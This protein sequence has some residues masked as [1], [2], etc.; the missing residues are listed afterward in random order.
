MNLNDL[1]KLEDA[2]K[3]VEAATVR[4]KQQNEEAKA[5]LLQRAA[6]EFRDYFSEAGF[7]VQPTQQGIIATI[8]QMS[9]K[10]EMD[11]SDRIGAFAHFKITPPAETKE[12]PVTVLLVR[13]ST[14][15]TTPTVMHVKEL[16]PLEEM[17]K[18][19]ADY[20]AALQR[21]FPETVFMIQKVAVA[22]VA[23]YSSR[24]QPTATPISASRQL[25]ESFTEVLSNLYPSS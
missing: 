17:E 18:K 9:F 15:D 25:F 6:T 13:K 14:A 24:P 11:G 16:T 12:E 1:K 19:A 2:R 5:A 20:E 21:P 3:R 22:K 8:G 4:L 23:P 10:L 7:S